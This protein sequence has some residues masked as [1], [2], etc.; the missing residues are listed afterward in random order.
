M[1]C[2]V[3]PCLMCQVSSFSSS[4]NMPLMRSFA[5]RPSNW[6][7]MLKDAKGTNGGHG[8]CG[9]VKIS[10]ALQALNRESRIERQPLV[11]PH[12]LQLTPAQA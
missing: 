9:F 10:H 8:I 11:S 2:A 1:F 6:M 7:T 3:T 5:L 4:T 12:P